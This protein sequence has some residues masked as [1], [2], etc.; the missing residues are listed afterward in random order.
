MNVKRLRCVA[1]VDNEEFVK[2][3]RGRTKFVL[4]VKCISFLYVQE[5]L[6]DFFFREIDVYIVNFSISTGNEHCSI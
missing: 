1:F 4:L 5:S 3:R 2:V 6:L